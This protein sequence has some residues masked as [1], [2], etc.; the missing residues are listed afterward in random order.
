MRANTYLAHRHDQDVGCAADGRQVGRARVR[1]RNRRAAAQ[2]EL[3]NG[4]AYDVAA[5]DDDDCERSE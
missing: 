1:H 4:A 3:G 5:P 2:A